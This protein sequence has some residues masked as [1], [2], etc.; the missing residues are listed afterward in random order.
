MIRIRTK[1]GSKHRVLTVRNPDGVWTT[2]ISAV[3]PERQGG[4]MTALSFGG[5][6]ENHLRAAETLRKKVNASKPD[7]IKCRFFDCENQ[8]PQAGDN[9]QVSCEICRK[10]MG[11][12]PLTF[13]S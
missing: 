11:L 9:E 6:G 4:F 8:H 13:C 2:V 5:A 1:I 12:E 3:A 10:E 7:E